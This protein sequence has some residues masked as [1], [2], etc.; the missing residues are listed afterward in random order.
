[1]ISLIICN[2]DPA[3]FTAVQAMYT[4]AL[5]DE[6]WEMIAIHDARSLAEGYNRGVARAK[7]D[8]L[9]FSHDDVEVISP[10]FPKRLRGHLEHFD[11][12]GVAGTSRLGNGKWVH[13]GPPHIFGQV[14]HLH[15]GGNI[16]I[17]IYGAP[18]RVV[19][20]IQALDGLFFAARRAVTD[21]VRFDETTFDH[22]HLYDLDFTFHAHVE[23]FRLAVANDINLIHHSHGKYDAVWATYARRFDQKWQTSLAKF[24]YCPAQW[25]GVMVKS[26]EQAKE[27]M[28]P[29]YWEE[30]DKVTG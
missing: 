19:G 3:R 24:P 26:R 18:R 4:A 8:I 25:A 9:V 10:D 21:K 6:P 30:D 20:N 11:L 27:V 1:M 15:P 5:G 23:G 7:G 28:N 2:I 17:D 12:I 29:P 14:C 22:F 13:A 16:G